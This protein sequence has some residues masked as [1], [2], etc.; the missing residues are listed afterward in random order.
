M[1]YTVKA[2]LS[3]RK[4]RGD[5]SRYDND[6]SAEPD[7]TAGW[8]AVQCE[9]LRLTRVRGVLRST[10]CGP[11]PEA[12]P[13][14]VIRRHFL[15][16]SRNGGVGGLSTVELLVRHPLQLLGREMHVLMEVLVLS[17]PWRAKHLCR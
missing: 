5:R 4:A 8:L 13:L 15:L 16:Q 10:V 11:R 1:Q 12:R 3:R 2:F 7:S 14:G 17:L 9:E 6:A